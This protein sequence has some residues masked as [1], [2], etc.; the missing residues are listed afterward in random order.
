MSARTLY[1]V[2]HGQTEWNA[3]RRMQGH[4]DS[5]LTAMGRMQAEV[6]GRTLAR[7][8]GI[9]AIVA[10]PLGRTRDTAAL[11]NGHLS[12][13][14]RHE[15]ALMERDC[16]TWSGLTLDEIMAAY[17]DEWQARSE[18]PFHHRPPDGENLPDMETRVAVC[19]DRLL[20][21]PERTLVLVTHG[22]MSR[23]I[24]KRLLDLPPERA[25]TVRHPNELFYR[26]EVGGPGCAESAYFLAGQGP[27]PGLLELN[28]SET[29]P[30]VIGGRQ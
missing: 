28:D 17:P 8:G 23:V 26:V 4:M 25:V 12:V 20:D 5:A 9:E 14:V 6:H 27:K 18:D 11:V 2:R 3:A 29:I 15:S 1:I 19:L 7:L 16:G 30:G 10:S 13:P 22:V 21:G 24:L